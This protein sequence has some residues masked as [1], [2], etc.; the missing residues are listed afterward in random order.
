VITVLAITFVA[1]TVAPLIFSKL[2]RNAFYVLAAV[3]AAAFVWL[4][5]Q[6]GPV[7]SG[8]GIEEVFPWIPNLK[9]EFAFRMDAL[10]WVMSLLILGVGSLV[11]VYCAR[12][13]TNK[14]A[15]LGGFGAQ[16]LAFAG[17]MFGLVTS[18][19]LLMMF[20]FWELTTVLSYLLIG[21]ARTRLAARRSALQAL[22][23]TTAGGLAMLVGLIILGQAA[24]TYRIS[25]ILD[26]AGT[27]VNGTTSGMVGAAVVLILVGAVTKSALVPFHF[28]LPGAMAAP[29][30]RTRSYKR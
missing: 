17:A 6:H 25:T 22:M 24:G 14:D 18:D 29:T 12:Y 9:L 3:P 7:Y 16:L 8:G 5:L 27:L 28:W 11:L 2:G 4:V 30:R 23:V 26:Q 20:I 1:A 21:Y 19:D 15:G 10:A 13:F